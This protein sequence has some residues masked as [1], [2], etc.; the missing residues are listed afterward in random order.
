MGREAVEK[1]LIEYSQ[2]ALYLREELNIGHVVL[3][4]V[5]V[6][7]F[8]RFIINQWRELGY[9]NLSRASKGLIGIA[10]FLSADWTRAAT[11]WFI[12]HTFGTQG[13][14][15]TDVA[16]LLV[17]LFVGTTGMLCAIRNFTPEGAWWGGHRLWVSSLIVYIVVSVI[18]WMVL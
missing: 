3:I 17:A 5:C 9:A 10:I 12:L 6:F 14:Y 2:A 7:L 18:N 16:P 1:V 4:P 11:I 15:L 8:A 13:N